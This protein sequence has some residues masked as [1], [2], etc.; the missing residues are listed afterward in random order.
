MT[1]ATECLAVFAQWAA[2]YPSARFVVVAIAPDG[3]DA[4]ELGWGLALPDHAF[5]YLPTINVSGQFRTAA[6]LIRILGRTLDARL[7]WV[8]PEPEH[9]PDEP[10]ESTVARG[11]LRANP[12]EVIGDQCSV[13]PEMLA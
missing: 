11:H 12:G 8:D 13:C 7:I 3:S 1:T 6:Q 10:E 2:D 9:W 4:E 5:A